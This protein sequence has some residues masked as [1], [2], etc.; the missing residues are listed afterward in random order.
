MELW[1]QLLAGAIGLF[2]I[3]MFFPGIKAT[4]EKSKNAKEKHW[5]TLVLLA[6]LLLGFVLLMIY[7]VQ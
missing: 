4:M 3:F 1:E 5:G 6:L 7:S 2:V